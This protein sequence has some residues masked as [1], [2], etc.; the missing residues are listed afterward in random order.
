MYTGSIAICLD[1]QG[2][3]EENESFEDW[4]SSVWEIQ[5]WAVEAATKFK[6]GVLVNDLEKKITDEGKTDEEITMEVVREVADSVD[7]MI[8]FTVDYPGNHKS[9]KM[10]VLD[11]EAA[12]NLN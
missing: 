5:G 9:G 4:T 10:P 3:L 6:D 12:I 2:V 8:K 7:E 11:V 1:W